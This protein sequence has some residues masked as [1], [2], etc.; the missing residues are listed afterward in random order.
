MIVRCE[1]HRFLL[2]DLTD[3]LDP[4]SYTHLDVYKRQVLAQRGRRFGERQSLDE[5]ALVAVSY[6][7]LDVYKRQILHLI[8]LQD[9]Q[10]AKDVRHFQRK[11][12]VRCV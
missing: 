10:T 7:H 4:V 8:E 11:I 6:T 3:E 1:K 2:G 5:T 12:L 9:L